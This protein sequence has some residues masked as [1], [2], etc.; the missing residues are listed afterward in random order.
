LHR[1]L[2]RNQTPRRL[3]HPT[4]RAVAPLPRAL[5]ALVVLCLDRAARSVMKVCR[6]RW[7]Q[8]DAKSCNE[9]R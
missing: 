8:A 1:R 4:T 7:E 2:R 3:K 6:L 9:K 5:A